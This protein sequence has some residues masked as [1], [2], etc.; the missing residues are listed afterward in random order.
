[1]TKITIDISPYQPGDSCYPQA[2]VII[3][4]RHGIRT[5]VVASQS[6]LARLVR[7]ISKHKTE[8]VYKDWYGTI[9]EGDQW[10]SWRS[11]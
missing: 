5:P 9:R 7:W 1:M 11:K 8:L 3:K 6:S 4:N 10:F 2:F